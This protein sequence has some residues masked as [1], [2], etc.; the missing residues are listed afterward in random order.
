M[1]RR[2]NFK[3]NIASIIML[4]VAASSF[5][6]SA[7]NAGITGRSTSGCSCH[8]SVTATV[9]AVIT[10][11]ATL[12]PSQQGSYTLTI[13]GGPLVSGGCCMSTSGGTLLNA[14]SDL[15]VASSQLTHT[16]AKL[17]SGGKVTFSFLYTAPATEGSQTIYAAG[18]S[19]D[20]T[21]DE[22]NDFWNKTSFAITVTNTTPVE[23]SSFAANLNGS[24]VQLNWSTATETNNFGYQIERRETKNSNWEKITFIKGNGNSSINHNYSY[25]DKNLNTGVYTYRLAQMDFNGSTAYYKLQGEVNITAPVNFGLSQNYPNP[26]NPSTLIK[27]QLPENSDVSLKIYNSAGKE[28]AQLVNGNVSAGV[29]EVSFDASHL[30]SGVYYYTI[31]AGNSFVQTKK[32]MILK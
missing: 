14:G 20:N 10:G 32:M 8:S 23:L 5:F 26:F 30:S 7:Y 25:T 2:Y 6:F 29:H 24:N 4:S 22:A 15:R 3:K 18:L 19:C 9:S 13:T 27:Y 21:G 16:T 17:A 12:K 1:V 31:T 11:P 28:V